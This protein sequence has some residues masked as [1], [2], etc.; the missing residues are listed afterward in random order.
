MRYQ[1]VAAVAAIGFALSGLAGAETKLNRPELHE[2]FHSDHFQLTGVTVSQQKRV[3]INYPRWSDSYMNAVEEVLPDGT[4]VPYPNREWNNWDLKTASASQHFV[5]VQSVVVDDNDV[6]WVVD[7]A[8]PLLTSPLPYGAKLVAIDLRTNTIIS[9]IPLHQPVIKADSYLND[10][11]IDTK[12]QVAYLTDSGAGGIVVVDLAI[13]QAHRTLDNDASVKPESGIQVFADGKVVER[14]GKPPQFASDGI[15]LDHAGKYLYYK[16]IT[17]NHLFRIPT[18]VLRDVTASPR[19]V[20]AAVENLGYAAPADGLWIDKHDSLYLTD[21]AKN[22][23]TLRV[24]N[25]TFYSVVSDRRLQ[26]PDTLSQDRDGLMYVTASRI[27][28][29][30]PFNNGVSVRNGSYGVFTFRPDGK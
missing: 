10:I 1:K 8:A 18:S 20:H 15:A 25:S 29:S 5:C 14:D 3:F 6:L 2:I 22:A 19:V 17:S 28:Q 9:T 27:N 26:W 24:A 12:R 30:P 21:P 4:S 16:A 11:R 13:K 23:V 7:A